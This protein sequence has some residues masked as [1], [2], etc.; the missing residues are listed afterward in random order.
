M[1]NVFHVSIE[2]ANSAFED[3]P[4]HEIARIL[5]KIAETLENSDVCGVCV[6]INGNKVGTFGMS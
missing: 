3:S 4:A 5:R 6:D 2:C 1:E